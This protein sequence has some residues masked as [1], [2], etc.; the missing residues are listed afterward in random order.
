MKKGAK[1][2][3][4]LVLL[5]FTAMAI[6]LLLVLLTGANIYQNLSERGEETYNR[7]TLSQY[8][9]TRVRQGN[10]VT[11]ED[12]KGCPALVFREEIEEEEYSTR[13]YCYD[14]YLRELFSPSDADLDPEDGEWIL[15]LDSMALSI[16]EDLLTIDLGQRKIQL[17]F[18]KGRQVA[19]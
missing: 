6:S 12:F 2:T 15:E 13:V 4:F 19:E 8:F 17:S 16:D 3:D 11:V 1:L 9:S 10:E 14:G 18:R 7:Q 5:V